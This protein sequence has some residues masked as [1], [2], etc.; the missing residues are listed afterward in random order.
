MIIILLKYYL[1]S[2]EC[3]IMAL[4][5]YWLIDFCYSLIDS[6]YSKANSTIL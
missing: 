4:C 6:A 1:E 3:Q 5:F 2:T